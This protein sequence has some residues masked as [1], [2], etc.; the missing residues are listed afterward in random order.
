[1]D[2]CV[3]CDGYVV[4]GSQVCKKCM[5]RHG[6]TETLTLD[7][8]YHLSPDSRGSSEVGQWRGECR[9]VCGEG[10]WT[11]ECRKWRVER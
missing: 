9:K 10:L 7:E 8:V 2:T 1:M 11:F 6:L 5:D 4:E 3:V